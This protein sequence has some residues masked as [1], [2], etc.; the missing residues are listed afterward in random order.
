MLTNLFPKGF[1][2]LSAL[3]CTR[4]AQNQTILLVR[5]LQGIRRRQPAV[6]GRDHRESPGRRHH[7]GE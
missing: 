3:R 7:L 6:R 4:R 1:M 2:A 5:L